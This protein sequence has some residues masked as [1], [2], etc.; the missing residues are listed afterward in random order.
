MLQAISQSYE[1][2]KRRADQEMDGCV[3]RNSVEHDMSLVM[4]KNVDSDSVVGVVGAFLAEK[5]SRNYWFVGWH[6]PHGGDLVSKEF[7]RVAHP[8]AGVDIIALAISRRNSPVWTQRQKKLLDNFYNSLVSNSYD[9]ERCAE[10][11]NDSAL[12]FK[13]SEEDLSFVTST[14]R[15]H[16]EKMIGTRFAY[17]VFDRR[18][19]T[20]FYNHLP[21]F[22]HPFT[23]QHVSLLLV[24]L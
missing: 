12:R 5:Y 17:A 23:S 2:A 10:P 3:N 15:G 7:F 24:P 14:Y 13:C 8:S 19:K 16:I 18:N 4:S 1:K 21:S 6:G 22:H 20:P 11:A 9:K